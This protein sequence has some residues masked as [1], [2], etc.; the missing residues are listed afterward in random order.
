MYNKVWWTEEKE[1]QAKKKNFRRSARIK[2][3]IWE[4]FKRKSKCRKWKVKQFKEG[5]R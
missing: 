5:K 4:K 3:F 2:W 1:R